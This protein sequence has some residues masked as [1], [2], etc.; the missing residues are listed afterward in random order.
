M[1]S[2]K[3]DLVY[4]FQ[5]ESHDNNHMKT[6]TDALNWAEMI[7]ELHNLNGKNE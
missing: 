1:L 7:I 4:R 5:G 3:L 2:L 6:V